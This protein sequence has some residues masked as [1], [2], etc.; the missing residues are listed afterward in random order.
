MGDVARKSK[1]NRA[2]DER[3]HDH[4]DVGRS[5]ATDR[6]RHRDETLVADLEFVTERTEQCTGLLALRLRRFGGCVPN[7]DAF[8]DLG[9]CVG[10]DSN[11]RT[12]VESLTKA[13]GGRSGDDR[14]QELLR[15]KASAK[16]LQHASHHLRLDTEHNDVTAP[17]GLRVVGG[18]LNAVLLS[19]RA[20]TIFARMAGDDR[21]S[22]HEL[23]L[24]HAGN[25]GLGHHTRADDG[26]GRFPER[27]HR[28]ILRMPLGSG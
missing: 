12:V 7:V 26:E 10:H 15:C 18:H 2:V 27:T 17:G 23:P 25:D 6:G 19:K 16:L 1:V 5:G 4:E 21:C 13:L 3:L 8:A 22:R 11:E 28:G 24:Q 14:D 9:W 20:S